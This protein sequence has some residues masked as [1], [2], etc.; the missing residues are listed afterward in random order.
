MLILPP[1]DS[2]II[3]YSDDTVRKGEVV[4]FQIDSSDKSSGI[5][6]EGELFTLDQA[7]NKFY[8]KINDE[9]FFPVGSP[10]YIPFSKEG[11]NIVIIRVFD[12]AGNY[13][14]EEVKIQVTK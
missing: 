1:P 3:N 13:K 7:L 14:E 12:E 8:I 10:V 2:L 4:R 9:P 11:E 5:P 6:N